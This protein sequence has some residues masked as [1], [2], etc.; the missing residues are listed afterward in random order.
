MPADTPLEATERWMQTFIA[1]RGTDEEA[2]EAAAREGIPVDEVPRFIRPS[3]SLTSIER[4]GVYRGMYL[5]RMQEALEADYPAVAH[6]LGDDGFYDLVAGYVDE[7]PS[8]SYSLNPL[9]DHL[10]SYISSLKG[11]RRRAFLSDLARLE[12][13]ASRAFDAEETP[14]LTAEDIARVPEDQWEH[15]RFKTIRA[16]ELLT[17]DYNANDY[18]QSVKD[19]NHDHPVPRRKETRLAVFR[20][21][22]ACYR[23]ELPKPAEDLLRALASGTPMGEAVT[24]AAKS[25][26]KK[27]G[28][29]EDHLF[30]WFRDWISQGIF[31]SI[32]LPPSPSDSGR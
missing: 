22:Y 21:N 8:R 15:A 23:L 4:V 12:L 32:Q 30:R 5:L 10:P 3:Q 19:E 27:G 14:V 2:L 20:R 11:V 6:F 28:I 1:H 9:G 31:Q 18:L 7:Y 25:L 16:F 24:A 13:A 17:L 29:K 26:K